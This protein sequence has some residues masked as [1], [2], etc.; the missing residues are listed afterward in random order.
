MVYLLI[1]PLKF[2]GSL[3]WRFPVKL[4]HS[5]SSQVLRWSSREWKF[6]KL[7][8]I[9]TYLSKLTIPSETTDGTGVRGWGSPNTILV[10]LKSL[11]NRIF[12]KI[13]SHGQI[14]TT[15]GG[16]I[17]PRS[18]IVLKVFSFSWINHSIN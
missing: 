16:L 8:W 10:N 4:L 3:L 13:S 12:K 15:L 14:L 1:R 5:V 11:L 6:M 7:L 2:L 17:P 9:P 18:S